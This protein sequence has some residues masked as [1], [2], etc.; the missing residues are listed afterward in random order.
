MTQNQTITPEDNKRLL[1]LLAEA[2][3]RGIRLPTN[4]TIPRTESKNQWNTDEN[5][6]FIRSDGRKFEAREEL[7]DFIQCKARFI[8]LRSGRGGG[9]TVSAAQKAMLKIKEGWSGAA[10]NPDF[11]NFKTSTWEELRKWIP[12]NMVVPRQ[13]YRKQNSWEPTRP[14]TMVFTNGAKLYC[15]GLKDPESARGPNINFLWYDEGRRDPTGLAWRNAIAAVRVGDNPQAWCST[16]P[17]GSQHWTT[18]FFNGEITPEVQ[19]ILDEISTDKTQEMFAIFS[20]SIERNKNNLDPM[21]YASILSSYPKGYL[22]A[23]EVDGM[24]ADEEGS[25]GDREW[26][27]DT[28]LDEEPDWINTAVR[29]WDLAG[30]EKKMTPQGKKNDPDSTIGTLLGTDKPKERFCIVDQIGGQWAWKTIKQNVVEVARQDGRE[31]KI[32]FEQEPA[33]GGKNQVAELIEHIQKELPGW[34][35]QGLEAKKLGDRVLAANTWFGEA[36]DGKWYIVKGGWNEAFFSELDYFPNPAIHDDRVTSTSGARHA[37]APIR[38]WKK[39]KFAHLGMK[40]ENKEEVP[41]TA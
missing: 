16:T 13:R 15:K 8:L 34:S 40:V 29:F 17:A 27:K 6:Y 2:K 23:R 11:E 18:T 5:G 20:T 19:K 3:V 4:I 12:W 14:F 31:V 30:T 22:R 25:L 28:I 32:Y 21:F 24:V 37:I 1:A 33:S 38:S 26:F 39:I 10:M 35:V 7:V 36:A 9:K 41:E